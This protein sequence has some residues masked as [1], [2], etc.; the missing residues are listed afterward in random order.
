M[1]SDAH[2][3]ERPHRRCCHRRGPYADAKDADPR[4][5]LVKAEKAPAKP[6]AEKD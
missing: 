3:P 2:L 1:A 5:E 6:K 4:W